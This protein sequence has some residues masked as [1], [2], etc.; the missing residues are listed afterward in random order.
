MAQG[1]YYE[2]KD[3]LNTLVHHWFFSGVHLSLCMKAEDQIAFEFVR[4]PSYEERDNISHFLDALSEIAARCRALVAR[5]LWI[6]M[7]Y[8]I[9]SNRASSGILGRVTARVQRQRTSELDCI[10][11]P[12]TFDLKLPAL[13]STMWHLLSQP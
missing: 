1:N 8:S 13:Q 5:N 12:A 6:F 4:A 3:N 9:S 7:S 10:V 11:L 2:H